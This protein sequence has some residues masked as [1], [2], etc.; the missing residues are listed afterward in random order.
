MQIYEDKQVQHTSVD[1]LQRP[2]CH[3]FN[4]SGYGKY[5]ES[6]NA[7]CIRASGGDVGGGGQR[8]SSLSLMG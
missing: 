3:T 2:S 5:E 1:G 8:T 4:C 6:D 7:E